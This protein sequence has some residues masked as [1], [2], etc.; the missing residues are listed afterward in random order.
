[1]KHLTGEHRPPERISRLRKSRVSAGTTSPKHCRNPVLKL[2][3]AAA[4]TRIGRFGREVM[5]TL[6]ASGHE[7]GRVDRDCR[8][9][10]NE[11]CRADHEDGEEQPDRQQ[12]RV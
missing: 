2:S 10:E 7:V 8:P 5:A 4:R 3:I 9:E 1:M 12:G 6:P 11:Q